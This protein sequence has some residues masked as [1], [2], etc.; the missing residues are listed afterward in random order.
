[1]SQLEAVVRR[2]DGLES[3]YNRLKTIQQDMARE[4]HECKLEQQHLQQRDEALRVVLRRE[5]AAHMRGTPTAIYLHLVSNTGPL[6]T[7]THLNHG[8]SMLV[9]E[10]A[11]ISGNATETETLF[12]KYTNRSRTAGNTGVCA[13]TPSRSRSTTRYNVCEVLDGQIVVLYLEKV[14]TKY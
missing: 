7:E 3:E 6:R 8:M 4:L 10:T 5:L 11:L 9:D 2:I 1:M 13:R 14:L 12:C